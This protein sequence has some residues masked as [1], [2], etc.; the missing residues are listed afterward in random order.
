MNVL[1]PP[2]YYT[3]F[4]FD[5]HHS[6]LQAAGVIDEALEE[7]QDRFGRRYARVEP[8][9]L[10]GAE[11]VLVAMGSMTGTMRAVV[12]ELRADG[13]KVGLLKIRSFRP[14][15]HKEVADLLGTARV[16]GVLDR[17]L[18]FGSTG[19]L[20][21]EVVR[22]LYGHASPPLALDFIVGLGGRDV[23]AAT[24]HRAAEACREALAAGKVEKDVL[25]PDA[26]QDLLRTWGWEI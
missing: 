2:D 23:S 16:V 17:S 6:M 18:S 3:E 4:E 20:Y 19:A 11:I 12:R 24:V 13:R 25:W 9:A 8:Y 14:F 22:C 1:V 10:D 7:F 15:P 26:R 21:Q 5:K